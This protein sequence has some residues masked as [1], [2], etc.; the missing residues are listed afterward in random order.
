MVLRTE[1]NDAEPA[2]DYGIVRWKR[3]LLGQSS[4]GLIAVGRHDAERTA[5]TY[6]LDARYATSTLF[7]ERE[8]RAGF[9]VAQTYVSDASHRFGVSQRVF[10]NYPNDLVEFS[11]DWARTDSTFDPRV[12]YLRRSNFQR[13]SSEFVISPRPAFLPFIRQLE[14]K[15]WEV[16]WYLDDHTRAFQSFSSEFRPLGATFRSGDS[17]ELNFQRRGDRPT[18]PFE[19]FEGVEVVPGTYWYNKYE[20]QIESYQARR[21]SGNAEFNTGGFYGG[22][23][24]ETTVEGRWKA[25]RHASVS[26]S[27]VNN[28]LTFED[29]GYLVNEASLRL[30]FAV[31]PTLFGA[32]AAQWNDEDDLTIVNFRLNWIPAPGS[33]VFLVINEQADSR[34][35]FWRPLATT[36]VTKLVW[37]I[38]F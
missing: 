27:Y 15:P 30:D 29:R 17:F 20:I 37:R 25:S 19:L 28:R 34:E 2:A 3:D 35:T 36:A 10:V 14:V 8:F 22:R 23:R 26:G 7:G 13:I 5:A 11:A 4:V 1:G 32:V 21:F 33:D 38:A 12:G 6:G 16:T 24:Q 9:A 31:S 18:E